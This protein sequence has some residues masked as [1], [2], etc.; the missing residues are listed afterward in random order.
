MLKL[1][2]AGFKWQYLLT[3]VFQLLVELFRKAA[4]GTFVTF[5][6]LKKSV[7]YDISV[8]QNPALQS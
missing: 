8:L 2:N 5:H 1:K 3:E 7:F 4:T 6:N